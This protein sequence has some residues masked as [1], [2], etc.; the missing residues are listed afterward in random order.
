MTES[1]KGTKFQ[2]IFEKNKPIKH[3]YIPELISWCK[4]FSELGLAPVCNGGCSSN[5]SFRTDD[6]FI[7][8]SSRANPENLKEED[9][10]EVVGADI[11]TKQLFVNGVKEPSSES[12][13]HHEIYQ[14]KHDI[15]AVFHGHDNLV[16][17]H[18][19]KLNLPITAK[20]QPYGTVELMWEVVKI[21]KDHNY[22]LIKNHGFIALGT[23]MDAAGKETLKQHNNAIKISKL[24]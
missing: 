21:L 9:L 3:E 6:G 14:R 22:L 20:E 19:D 1:Y 8:T 10:T 13:I 17:K 5:L 2:T 16:L 11:S 23:T 18:N 4:R 15:N 24:I 7:I 12:F